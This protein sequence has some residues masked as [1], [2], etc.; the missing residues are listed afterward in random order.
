MIIN[1]YIAR[2]PIVFA[3][4]YFYVF[5]G[6][7]DTSYFEKTIGRLDAWTRAWSKA[8]DLV[9]GRQGHNAIYDGSSLIV[10]GSNSGPMKTEK[11]VVSNGKVS[12]RL[13]N[14]DLGDYCYYPE[15]FL[16]PVDFCKTSP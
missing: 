15:L 8:G 1:K 11:C 14:P 7:S 5:G 4:G 12:C 3:D 9:T 2:A 6:E 10:I 16:V 13:Q